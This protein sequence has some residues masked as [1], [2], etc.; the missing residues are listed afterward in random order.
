[1]YH[2]LIRN[3]WVYSSTTYVYGGWRQGRVG[4]DYHVDIDGHYYSML[5]RLLRQQVEAG[6][7]ERTVELFH[8]SERVACHLLGA[9]AAAT[10]ASSRSR[11]S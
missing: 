3:K 5:H 10:P 7:T 4:L 8:R 6:I 9:C 11:T 2:F 1:M